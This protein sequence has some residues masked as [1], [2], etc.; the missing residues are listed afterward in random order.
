MK[1]LTFTAVGIDYPRCTLVY[2]LPG[3][4]VTKYVNVSQLPEAQFRTADSAT[5][6][7]LVAHIGMAYIPQLFALE[8]FDVV[9]VRP[10]RIS[11]E[12]V[13]FYETY[14]QRGLAELRLRNGLDI[15]KRIHL[16]I[17][18]GAP[19]YTVGRYTPRRS[20]L[21][22]NG[23]GKD[24]V[25]AGDVLREI[26]LPFAWFTVGITAAMRRLIRLSG[27]PRS[28]TFHYGGSLRVMREKT[29]YEGHRP[30]T[31]LVAFMALL[32]AF[33]Q[34][35][36]Y[37][38]A[39]NE[40]SANFGNVTIDGIEVNHQYPKSHHFETSFARYVQA[41]ILPD[42]SYFSILRPLYEIQ[43]AKLFA[44]LPKYF[45]SFR[46]CN[47][48]H[49]ADYWCLRC[50]KCAFILLALAPHLSERELVSV[51]G[52]NAFAFPEIR[53]WI[54]KLCSK[55]VRPFECVGTRSE[56]LVALWMSRGKHPNDRF[57]QSLYDECCDGRNMTELEERHMG[58]IHRSH[59]IPP[60][61]TEPVMGYFAS[62]LKSETPEPIT[63]VSSNQGAANRNDPP[64]GDLL[65]GRFSR[66][67]AAEEEVESHC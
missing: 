49:R 6:Q 66:N 65:A 45:A 59:S 67:A 44:G 12:G 40:Y 32:G 48:G 23:G 38:V 31:S 30:F 8:D 63:L 16:H 58:R 54:V 47:S 62:R 57:I 22:M 11:P 36:R 50:P 42:V 39:A 19:A 17:E 52:A 13:E 41:E 51:F 60:E 9:K 5:V 14:F 33:V 25:I 2:D 56:S 7:H 35:H 46:S 10:L 43:I 21:L 4:Q 1:R 53:R 18:P 61:L 3:L 34:R 26:G 28:L 15:G 20:A 27:N 24:T 37:I 29:R 55:G 64:I